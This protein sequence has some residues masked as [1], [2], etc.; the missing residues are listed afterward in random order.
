MQGSNVKIFQNKDKITTTWRT[1]SIDFFIC[2]LEK[3]IRILVGKN[4]KGNL[5]QPTY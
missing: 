3:V 2:G 5:C 4:K 1:I